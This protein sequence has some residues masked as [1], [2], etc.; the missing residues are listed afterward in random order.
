[1]ATYSTVKNV[2]GTPVD[3][4]AA[5]R[6]LGAGEWG[7]ANVDAQPAKGHVTAGRLAVV[8]R[9]TSSDVELDAAA[10][11][12]FDDTDARNGAGDVDEQAEPTP[13]TP[14]GRRAGTTT[15]A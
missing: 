9:P 4:T 6:M 1:M 15:E 14:R 13:P 3:L 5:G 12:A 11:A 7:T 8:T 10:L 2:G